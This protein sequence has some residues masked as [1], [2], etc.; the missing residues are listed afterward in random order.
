MYL[1][2]CSRFGGSA[3]D[4]KRKGKKLEA[5]LD[6]RAAAKCYQVEPGT[7]CNPS[8]ESSH[9]CS[10]SCKSARSIFAAVV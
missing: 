1:C 8:F 7:S 6:V 10:L 3:K 2:Q 4:L 5:E 9:Y